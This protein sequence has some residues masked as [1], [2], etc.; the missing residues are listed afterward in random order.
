MITSYTANLPTPAQIA[1]TLNRSDSTETFEASPET[2]T[3]LWEDGGGNEIRVIGNEELT[4]VLMYDNES[5][6]NFYPQSPNRQTALLEA[7][8]EV[9]E[10]LD[11]IHSEIIWSWDDT[12]KLW[13]TAAFWS[14]DNKHW[15]TSYDW[16]ENHD[17]DSIE[18]MLK[19]LQEDIIL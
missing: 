3:I 8:D 2:R 14:T 13:Y 16:E 12:G 17:E 7:P 11:L 10:L 5:E 15:E 18:W 9:Q 6:Q 19:T 1:D 4:I